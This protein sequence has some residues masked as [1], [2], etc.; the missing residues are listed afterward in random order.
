MPRETA[1]DACTH[2]QQRILQRKTWETASASDHVGFTVLRWVAGWLLGWGLLPRAE[3]PRPPDLTSPAPAPPLQTQLKQIHRALRLPKAEHPW[4][5]FSPDPAHE[6][7]Q[8]WEHTGGC[9]S[10]TFMVSMGQTTTTASATPA[11]SPQMRPRVLSSRPCSSLMWLLRNSNIPNLQRGHRVTPCLPGQG[12]AGPRS[13]SVPGAAAHPVREPSMS[14]RAPSKVP[15]G[16]LRANPLPCRMLR[17]VPSN[18][19]HATGAPT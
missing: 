10:P 9:L 1:A 13:G 19:P 7:V 5:S 12:A 3:G 11:P 18:S 2:G 17:R 8:G 14:R 15:L 4:V 6:G 16:A